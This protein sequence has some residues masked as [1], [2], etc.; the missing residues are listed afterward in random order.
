MV[1]FLLCCGFPGQQVVAVGGWPLAGA[2]SLHGNHRCH[3]FW[4]P[5]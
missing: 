1:M 3:S 5:L 2:G 4:R